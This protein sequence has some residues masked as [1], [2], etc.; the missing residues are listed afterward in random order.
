MLPEVTQKGTNDLL[1][2]LVTRA[3]RSSDRIS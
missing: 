2:Q 1:G 3:S